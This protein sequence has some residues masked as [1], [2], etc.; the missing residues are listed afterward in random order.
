MGNYQYLAKSEINKIEIELTSRCNAA[1]PSCNRTDID[2]KAIRSLPITDIT[3]SEFVEILSPD[4]IRGRQIKLC[5]VYGDPVVAPDVLEISQYVVEND[6]Q[7]VINTN[8]SMRNEKFWSD[9][10]HL[11]SDSEGSECIFSIDGLED[12]NAIY[13]RNTSWSKIMQNAS[14]YIKAGGYAHW[15]YLVFSHNEHQVEE[16]QQLAKQMGF[17]KFTVKKTTRASEDKKPTAIEV[18]LDIKPSQKEEYRN[19]LL[20]D[21]QPSHDSSPSQP[22]AESNTPENSSLWKKITGLGGTKEPP[23]IACFTRGESASQSIKERSVYI[24]AQKRLWPCCWWAGAEFP[25]ARPVRDLYRAVGEDFNL[26]GKNSID[27]VINHAWFKRSL[28]RSWNSMSSAPQ[29]CSKNC[30]RA[31]PLNNEDCEDVFL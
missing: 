16:A 13:R 1:C 19:S 30:N 2:G 7:L 14:A 5:G 27:D 9:L 23:P 26:L 31:Q 28:V 25:R 17:K 21:S 3:A 29:V 6:G 18:A 20:S 15:D 4:W 22:Q 10:G 24:S 8:A 12:T 11:M